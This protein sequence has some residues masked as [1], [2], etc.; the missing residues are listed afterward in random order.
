METH[1]EPI[2]IE[3]YTRMV[4]LHGISVDPI[5]ESPEFRSEYLSMM[6]EHV[7]NLPEQTLLHALTTMRKQSKLPRSRDILQVIQN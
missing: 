4:R 3:V 2:V 7:G 5:L 6:R 1:M